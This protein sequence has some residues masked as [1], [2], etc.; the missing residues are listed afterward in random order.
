MSDPYEIVQW[1]GRNERRP[2]ITIV[3]GS[4]MDHDSVLLFIRERE[5]M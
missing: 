3:N 5:C 1:L 4:V 2:L